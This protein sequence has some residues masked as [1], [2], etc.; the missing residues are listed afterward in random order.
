MPVNTTAEVWVPAR[1]AFSVARDEAE[2]ARFLRM[3]DG[4]A[5]FAAGSGT[6]RFSAPYA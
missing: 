6:Y 3:R 2:G 4:C 5:V 1:R